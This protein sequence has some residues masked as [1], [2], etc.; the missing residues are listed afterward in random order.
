MSKFRDG[1][2]IAF[3]D[4]R[5]WLPPRVSDWPQPRRVRDV[6]S[7]CRW[8]QLWWRKE[9]WACG[10]TTDTG[11]MENVGELH[12]LRSGLAIRADVP[13]CYTWLHKRCHANVTP[14]GIPFLLYQ[15]WVL[16]RENL[17]WVHLAMILRRHL[18]TP[19][20]PSWRDNE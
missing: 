1:L 17:S 19:Q 9:C 3:D 11:P 6:D 4:H 16:D 12:H 8:R 7:L 5:T 10:E 14:D 2:G 20:P 15:K 18:P 13:T